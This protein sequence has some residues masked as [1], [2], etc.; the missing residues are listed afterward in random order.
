MRNFEEIYEK[1]NKE[2]AQFVKDRYE[3]CLSKRKAFEEKA[4]LVS[5]MEEQR[6]MILD[7]T[8]CSVG[9]MHTDVM[10]SLKEKMKWKLSV[11]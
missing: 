5:A 8:Y 6:C 10:V 7:R 1:M 9:W 3:F 4:M 11:W 2:T